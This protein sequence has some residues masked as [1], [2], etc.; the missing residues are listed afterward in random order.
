LPL[1]R[2]VVGTF[3]AVSTTSGEESVAVAWRPAGGSSFLSPLAATQLLL[4]GAYAKSCAT[5]FGGRSL[6]NHP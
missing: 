2:A 4:T 5:M 6:K 1:P 3:L